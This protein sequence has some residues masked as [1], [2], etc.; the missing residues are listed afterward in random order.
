[1]Q[2]LLAELAELAAHLRRALQWKAAPASSATPA[3][4]DAAEQRAQM[5]D[6]LA[7]AVERLRARVAEVKAI[8]REPAPTVPQAPVAPRPPHKHSTSAIAR[9]RNKRKLRRTV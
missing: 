6:A 8:E 5:T 9:W 2:M 1:M 3:D 4:A 7:A